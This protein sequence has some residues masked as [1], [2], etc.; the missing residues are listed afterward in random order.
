MLGFIGVV[1]VL[2]WKEFMGAAIFNGM[3][4]DNLGSFVAR[5]LMLFFAVAIYPVLIKKWKGKI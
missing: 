3:L 1:I 4:G 2:S 5:F